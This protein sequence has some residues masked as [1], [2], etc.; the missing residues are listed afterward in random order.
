MSAFALVLSHTA[1]NKY[2]IQ[3]SEGRVS[4]TTSHTKKYLITG[5]ASTQKY[6]SITERQS[7]YP[8]GLAVQRNLSKW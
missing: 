2:D 1:I 5:K 3:Q 8:F 7:S 4:F 6:C